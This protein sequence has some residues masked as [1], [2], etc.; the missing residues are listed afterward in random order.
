MPKFIAVGK[1][2]RGKLLSFALYALSF[3]NFLKILMKNFEH[4]ITVAQL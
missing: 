1:G 3:K 2:Q 4:T